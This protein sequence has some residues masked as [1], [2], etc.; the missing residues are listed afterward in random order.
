MSY[1]NYKLSLEQ[2]VRLLREA[3]QVG[4]KA[5]GLDAMREA[6]RRAYQLTPQ[7]NDTLECII[8]IHELDWLTTGR[9][10]YY[11]ESLTQAQAM[12]NAKT[13]IT[14][15]SALFDK[16][17]T[18]I[19]SAPPGLYF[20]A[21]KNSMVHNE[22]L[23]QNAE[24][25]SALLVTCAPLDY[26]AVLVNNFG[27]FLK[28]KIDISTPRSQWGDASHFITVTYRAKP[29]S[30]P[31]GFT[32]FA[33]TA[34]YFLQSVN[35]EKFDEYK[36][37]SNSTNCFNY[38]GGETLNDK[39]LARQF[40]I[41]RYIGNFLLYKKALPERIREGL[42]HL[43][44]ESNTSR[45]IKNTSPRVLH[46]PPQYPS[47][48]INNSFYRR[49]HFRQLMHERFYRG[50]HKNKKPGSRVVLVSDAFVGA[51]IDA[52]TICEK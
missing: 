43:Q 17:E 8:H 48:K 49:M 7:L 37:L 5:K 41:T 32:R 39:E 50:E 22:K 28:A 13:S 20:D 34:D 46:M 42:P 19:L 10:V 15:A 25:E 36:A 3:K 33:N 18:F 21:G 27:N 52:K 47:E 14:N 11:P 31:L 44:K 12:L 26:Q 2:F 6:L 45:Y 1:T 40:N 35:F 30:D 38:F 4:G 23:A 29:H 9:V 16:P 51:D 24:R